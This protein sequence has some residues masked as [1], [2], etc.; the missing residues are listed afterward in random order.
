MKVDLKIDKNYKYLGSISYSR[1]RCLIIINSLNLES[2]RHEVIHLKQYI[3]DKFYFVKYF[4]N[5]KYR[6]KSELEAYSDKIELL[7]LD[8]IENF[9]KALKH[10]YFLNLDIL[11]INL[12]IFKYRDSLKLKNNNFNITFNV[13]DL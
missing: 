10:Q 4:L 6:L 5:S 13:N 9:S 2:L 3:R 7:T 12:E 8:E 1:K 11:E